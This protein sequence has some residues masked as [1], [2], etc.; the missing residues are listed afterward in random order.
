RRTERMVVPWNSGG[1]V[2]MEGL[3]HAPGG[4]RG[5]IT[6]G[7]E[8]ISAGLAPHQ[9]RVAVHADRLEERR[10]ELVQVRED[11]A[12]ARELHR[13]HGLEEGVG[14]CEVDAR[15]LAHVERDFRAACGVGG[16]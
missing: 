6:K 1:F 2:F 7:R 16:E 11:H 13:L 4:R 3:Y 8:G 5:E 9:D 10:V 14:V 12:L 15:H